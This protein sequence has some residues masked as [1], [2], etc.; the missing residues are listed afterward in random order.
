[1]KPRLVLWG[2]DAQD[3]RVLI[4][5]ELR[6]KDNKVNVYTFPEHV[7]TE[8]FNQK[9]MDEW[10]DGA[11]LDFP[12][13]YLITERELTV[14]DSLL[15]DDLKVERA[16]VVHRAQSEWHFM[17]LSSKLNESY[18]AEL[19]DLKERIEKLESYENSLW[20]ELKGFWDKVQAQVRDRNLFREHANNLRD[21]T[22]ALFAKMKEMRNKL[23]EEFDKISKK[24][25]DAFLEKISNIEKKITEGFRL[26]PLFDEL[27]ELQRTFRDSKLSREHRAIVWEKLDNTFKAVKEKRFPGS[28]DDKSPV[29][30]IQRRYEGLLSAIEKMERSIKRDRDDLDFQNRK[31]ETT[32]GQLEAQIRQ[33][34]IKMIN[35]R[36]SSKE[37]KLNE[38]LT[39][40][41]D[42]EQ[43]INQIRSK[44]SEK[45]KR[46][47]AKKAAQDKIAQ[48]MK[49]RE[50][51]LK[52]DADKLAKAAEAIV[53]EKGKD[54]IESE[55]VAADN[56]SLLE[57]ISDHIEDAV[58]TVRAVAE[59]VEERIEDAVETFFDKDDAAEADNADDVPASTTEMAETST[60]AEEE[61][62]KED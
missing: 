43:R 15:P 41:Q 24:N 30:R 33:A 56:P 11:L 36:I 61:E 51:A 13:G 31:I 57:Q 62:K 40:K 50:E 44:E 35:E 22:N 16:D 49:A 46:E 55:E 25:L 3:A 39:T 26:Q 23:D 34:K 38:M 4:A 17:V 48:E 59:V 32:D 1:M 21:A 47:E 54:A 45:E 18:N 2:T 29:D 52:E 12:E 14:S 53:G 9:M 7:V 58:D 19:M 20:D 42:L 60:E 8:E 10:R 5:L 6:P 27:K 37:E 28:S